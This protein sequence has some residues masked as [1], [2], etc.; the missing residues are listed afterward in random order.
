MSE[1]EERIEVRIVEKRF[2]SNEGTRR[3]REGRTAQNE[4]VLG[5]VAN[6]RSLWFQDFPAKG[7][8]HI[9]PKEKKKCQQEGRSSIRL[10]KVEGRCRKEEWVSF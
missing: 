8:K 9:R 5:I 1:G 3:C 2:S 6:V 10:E 7:T 4:I